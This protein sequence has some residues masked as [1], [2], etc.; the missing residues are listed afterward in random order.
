[1]P[2]EIV[3]PRLS[4]TMDKGT[5]AHW[6][7]KA[8]DS[9]KRGEV[10]LEIETDKAN[11]ELESYTDGI[12]ARVMVSE[13]ETADVGT[14]IGIV[15]ADAAELKA[16]QSGEA[17]S[18]DGK[19]DELLAPAA[20][21]D[22]RTQPSRGASEGSEAVQAESIAPPSGNG[23]L[24]VKASPLAR[25][26]AE[27]RHIDLSRINGSGPGG[28]IVRED[29]E[30]FAES[31]APSEQKERQQ[32]P[33][34]QPTHTDAPV[35]DEVVQ[36]SRMQLTVGRRLS[37]SVSTAPHFFVTSEIDMT[38]AVRMRLQIN[39]A[40][41]DLKVSFN[42]LVVKAAAV[43]LAKFPQVNASV[44]YGS[45]VRHGHVNIGI[46]VD[47]PD[48]LIVPVLKDVDRK[49]L[50][51]IATE[52]RELVEAA[53]HAKLKPDN[54]EGGTFTVSNLGMFGVD[55]FT[56]I[57]NPPESAILAVGAIQEKPVVVKGEIVVRSRMR[58]TLS[59][60]HRVIYGA[61]AAAF[62]AELRRTLEHPVLALL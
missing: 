26:I 33:S 6:N 62:L 48:G 7:K 39:E 1:M 46:A 25:R 60:D 18:G 23:S 47:L 14:P 9:V 2:T 52:A 61:G 54:F 5:V 45:V 51:Q 41:P 16:I 40:E 56:A 34:Q 42:D 30:S 43:T 17:S 8:G 38:H 37:E 4:D 15:A 12:L 53:R 24:R 19:A 58:V 20:A 31:G 57:I 3:M 27:Q 36:L 29:V 59:C 22:A 32:R 11:M 28:R 13:G 21:K 35:E 49:G 50:R 55:Q 44:D 10:L